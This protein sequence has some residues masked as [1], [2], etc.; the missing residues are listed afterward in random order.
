V[1]ASVSKGGHRKGPRGRP[2]GPTLRV[3]P[4]GALRQAVVGQPHARWPEPAPALWWRWRRS[5]LLEEI[6]ATR[7]QEPEMRAAEG[8]PRQPHQVCHLVGA[9]SPR[10]DQWPLEDCHRRHRQV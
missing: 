2:L 10:H 5:G 7:P 9:E 8:R 6:A 1:R 3:P 4:S